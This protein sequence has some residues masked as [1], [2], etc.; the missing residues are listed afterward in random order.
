[1]NIRKEFEVFYFNLVFKIIYLSMKVNLYFFFEFRNE[2]FIL[3]YI[4]KKKFIYNLVGYLRVFRNNIRYGNYFLY[5]KDK[6][7]Y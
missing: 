4:Y 7:I 3:C 2:I 5:Y 1:M 6:I